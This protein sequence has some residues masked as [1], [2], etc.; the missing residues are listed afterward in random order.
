MLFTSKK[1]RPFSFKNCLV[2]GICSNV[3]D[4]YDTFVHVS[5]NILRACYSNQPAVA[6]NMSYMIH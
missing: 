1:N 3:I 6:T 4:K 2:N 5:F